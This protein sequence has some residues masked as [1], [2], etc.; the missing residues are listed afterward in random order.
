MVKL[1]SCRSYVSI[2]EEFSEFLFH[3]YEVLVGLNIVFWLIQIAIIANFN[4]QQIACN[5]TQFNHKLV[6]DLS[7]TVNEIASSLLMVA[8]ILAMVSNHCF[9]FCDRNILKGNK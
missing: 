1:L 2:Y 9:P 7:F 3:I 8:I 6:A 5:L 4:L